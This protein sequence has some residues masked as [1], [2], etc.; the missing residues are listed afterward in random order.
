MQAPSE[1]PRQ[2]QYASGGQNYYGAGW[3]AGAQPGAPE[4]SQ[5][6]KE[7]SSGWDKLGFWG[8]GQA[9]AEEPAQ[10]APDEGVLYYGASEVCYLCVSSHSISL[11]SSPGSWPQAVL[12]CKG[13]SK[14][15]RCVQ[16]IAAPP[17]APSAHA[18]QLPAQNPYGGAQNP[19]GGFQAPPSLPAAQPQQGGPL[20]GP[21][22]AGSSAASALPSAPTQTAHAPPVRNY[23]AHD[24]QP[25]HQPFV[26]AQHPGISAAPPVRSQQAPWQPDAQSPSGQLQASQHHAPP[27]P[28]SG[29]RSRPQSSYDQPQP[30]GHEQTWQSSGPFGDELSHQQEAVGII[31]WQ[32]HSASNYPPAKGSHR[33]EVPPGGAAAMSDTSH[34]EPQQPAHFDHQRQAFPP[35]DVSTQSH[36]GEGAQPEQPG[37]TSLNAGPFAAADTSE[38]DFWGQHDAEVLSEGPFASTSMHQ[39]G[40][41]DNTNKPEQD[42][43]GVAVAWSDSMPEHELNAQSASTHSTAEAPAYRPGYTPPD[44]LPGG[45]VAALQGPPAS[46][47]APAADRQTAQPEGGPSSA[48]AGLPG[49]A[50][51][52]AALVATPFG[53]EA[54]QNWQTAGSGAM[55]LPEQLPQR[56][57][58]E[59]SAGAGGPQAWP[60]SQHH[61]AA[62]SSRAPEA[63]QPYHAGAEQ[64][65]A[66]QPQ[67][68]TEQPA[69]LQSQGSHQ[70]EALPDGIHAMYGAHGSGEAAAQHEGNSHAGHYAAAA[71]HLVPDWQPHPPPDALEHSNYGLAYQDASVAWPGSQAAA[72]GNGQDSSWA[73]QQSAAQH[74]TQQQPG[75]VYMPPAAASSGA[76][77]QSGQNLWT[78][79]QRRMPS[80]V[81]AGTPQIFPSIRPSAPF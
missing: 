41:P 10:P 66:T 54:A 30:V 39:G 16:A 71:Q 9:A 36:D 19:Y 69:W 11:A 59:V 75:Q 12:H 22:P 32:A 21:P 49:A 80:N 61:G 72:N 65:P 2:D 13:M 58:Q 33:T 79:Q 26:P 23:A 56:T 48:A 5:P 78:A 63:D 67:A 35:P 73:H 28:P 46:S 50:Q 44:A 34:A 31:P 4:T 40:P 42:P 3:Q 14:I 74:G 51:P 70:P 29:T 55:P 81:D 38:A 27:W 18:S 7:S 45:A 6:A 68:V 57:A 60:A 52:N 1:A 43:A 15:A 64:H 77:F 17:A 25:M 62:H 53:S 24:A 20:F 76:L 47:V 37:G 8:G